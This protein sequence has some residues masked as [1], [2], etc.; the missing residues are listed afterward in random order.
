M[1]LWEAVLCGILQGLTEFL[2]VSS[3]GHLALAHA[4]FGMENAESYLSFDILLHLATLIVVFT[5]YRKD[6]FALI[7]AFF[8]LTG[9]IFRGNFRFS[10][11]NEM[12][13]MVLLLILATLP[14]VA[15]FFVKDTLEAIAG[16]TRIVGVI[17]F[18]NGILLLCAD[19]FAGKEK[20]AQLSPRGALGVGIF[21][22]FAVI[23]G[24]SRSGSTISG[25]ML[26]GLSRKNAVRFSFLMSVPA[27]LGANIMNIPE[28]FSARIE[29][30]TLGYYLIGMVAAAVSG[31]FAMRLLAYISA[32]EKFGF[33]AYY[34][35]IIG[36]LAVV[37][38]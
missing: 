30:Q 14:L 9:K 20:K 25:G 22:L 26:F 2:P 37:F 8:T 5:V 27:I 3:S 29:A 1:T 24:L 32:K 10:S 34:C 36:V 31:F 18:L 33:F 28:A 6:I 17:L 16:Y 19:R 15:A 23:P 12:E 38:G 11:Y 35:M 4:F 13:R 21:Q 7:P